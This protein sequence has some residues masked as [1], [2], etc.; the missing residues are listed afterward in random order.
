VQLR[1]TDIEAAWTVTVQ[2]GGLRA[3]RSARGD[4]AADTVVSG[5]AEDL[6]LIVW[7]RL[8]PPLSA[9]RLAGLASVLDRFLATSYIPD[10]RT[11]P[12]H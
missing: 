12:A 7:K 11:T 3:G 6:A 9:A 2:D 1:A 8:P 10:P 4:D 5:P